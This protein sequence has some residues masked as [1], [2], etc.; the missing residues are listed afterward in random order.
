MASKA[1]AL[2]FHICIWQVR[3]YYADAAFTGLV[4]LGFGATFP[5]V[6][7]IATRA[8]PVELMTSSLAIMF[9]SF[10]SSRRSC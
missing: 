2:I 7:D 4:G 1:L 6:L 5:T 3:S 9:V 10:L 8:I